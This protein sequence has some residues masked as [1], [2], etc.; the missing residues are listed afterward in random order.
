[1]PLY[2]PTSE[3]ASTSG[4]ALNSMIQISSSASSL[5]S[6]Y[7]HRPICAPQP[8][9][10][11]FIHPLCPTLALR[12]ISPADHELCLYM[13]CLIRTTMCHLCRY[14]EGRVSPSPL[15]LPPFPSLIPTLAFPCEDS[16]V[17]N[18]NERQACFD[19]SM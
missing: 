13:V 5:V 1:M 3:G 6:G 4:D 14:P 8:S 15:P 16:D 7:A 2:P 11:V 12:S 17:C 18:E 19:V 10:Y 9:P